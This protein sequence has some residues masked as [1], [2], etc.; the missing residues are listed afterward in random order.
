MSCTQQY[1]PLSAALLE[2]KIGLP[3]NGQGLCTKPVNLVNEMVDTNFELEE[4]L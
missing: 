3:N 4:G 2:W 1:G